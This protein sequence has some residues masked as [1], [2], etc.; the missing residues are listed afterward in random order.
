[1]DTLQIKKIG[2]DSY[3]YEGPAWEKLLCEEKTAVVTSGF[4]LDLTRRHIARIIHVT[5]NAVMGH[6]H[7]HMPA[8]KGVKRGRPPKPPRPPRPQTA[9]RGFRAR[10]VVRSRTTG[11]K[12]KKQSKKFDYVSIVPMPP[13][14]LSQLLMSNVSDYPSSFPTPKECGLTR[15]ELAA[16]AKAAYHD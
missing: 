5:E 14:S 2:P 12:A 16:F 3:Q 13:K 9:F 7:R 4:V 11:G 6:F 15:E 10:E 1:M 8:Y